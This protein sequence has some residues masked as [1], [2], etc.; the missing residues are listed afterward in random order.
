MIDGEITAIFVLDKLIL[1]MKSNTIVCFSKE[2]INNI[3]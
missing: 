3:L 2:L 1:K